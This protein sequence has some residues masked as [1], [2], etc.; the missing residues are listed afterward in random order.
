MVLLAISKFLGVDYQAP[1]PYIPT[2]VELNAPVHSQPTQHQAPSLPEHEQGAMKQFIK[3]T[4][5]V[6]IN[7]KESDLNMFQLTHAEFA[8]PSLSKS[9]SNVVT[10]LLI[11]FVTWE[12]IR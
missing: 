9:K 4:L 11:R 5:T 3:I 2:K 6:N 7:W 8:S 12:A 1:P 10:L